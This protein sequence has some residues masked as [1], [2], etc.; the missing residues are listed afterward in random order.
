MTYD[1]NNIFAKIIRGELPCHQIYNDQTTIAFM[2]IMPQSPG[3]IV[4]V[5]KEAA[6]DF[7]SLTPASAQAAILIV[8]KIAVAAKHAF[9]ESSG[10]LISQHNGK[11]ANQSIFHCHFHV[12]PCYDNHSIKPHNLQS[13]NNHLNENDHQAMLAEQAKKMI[14][15]LKLLA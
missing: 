4:V 7:L 14:A 2:D 8:Q 3:H 13:D 12:I 1:S 9:K 15:A 6:I 10:I 5:P 11:T